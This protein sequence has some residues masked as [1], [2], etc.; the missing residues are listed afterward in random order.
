MIKKVAILGSTGS[1]GKTLI[2]ILKKDKKKYN[3]LLLTANKNINILLKQIK[4]FKVKNIIVSDLDK[5]NKIRIILKNKKI[6]IYNNF[7]SINRIL[8]NKKIDYTMSSISG[9]EGLGP[10][11]KIIPHTKEIAIANKESIICAWHLIQKE[12]I[13][14]RTKFIP[15]DSEHFSIYS[16]LSSSKS[17]NLEKVFITASGGPFRN[18]PLKK[19]ASIKLESALKHP[20][21]KMGQKIT[22]DSST[23]MNKIFEIIEAKKIFNLDY[24][25]DVSMDMAGEEIV[26][27]NLPNGVVNSK[28]D[29]AYLLSW[30]DYYSPGLL[31]EILNHNIIAKVALKEFVLNNKKYDYGTIL[32]PV[33]NQNIS[34]KSLYELLNKLANKN[35]LI[36]DGVNTG[37]TNGI[38]LGSSKF[39]KI[40]KQNIAIIVGEGVNS[41]DAGEIWHLFD[42]RYNIMVT[43][44]DV[45]SISRSDLSKYSSIIIPSSKGLSDMNSKKIIE[46]TK[47]GG[48][49]ITF[50]NSL[51]WVNKNKLLDLKI[52]SSTIPTK[53]VSFGQKD[54]HRGAQVIGGAIFEAKLDLSHP[55]SF[56]YKN[57]HI[58]LFRNT[59]IFMDIDEISYNNPI[60]YTE[61]PLLSGYVSEENLE[62]LKLSVPFKTG[63]YKKGQVT[64]FTDNTNFRAF[65][66]G[67]NKLLMNAIYFSDQF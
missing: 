29:Y 55:I 22:I 32:I 20:N 15:I 38:D 60:I 10:T 64:C 67:T 48:N 4:I 14:N 31:N 36:I 18:Y 45:K 25:M 50:K 30:N 63:G 47:N 65:W 56:G 9:I 3:I 39:K 57:E 52:K 40:E 8:K 2:N 23:L 66:Y 61:S 41:Y 58:S 21:W 44:L 46:W 59:T 19:F 53:N 33:K 24:N 11:I 27:L 16:L 17:E 42:T 6:N 28:S 13:M 43:K 5:F 54:N 7:N 37:L 1:I 51:N 34:S 49:L 35:H 12:L 26:N 62:N